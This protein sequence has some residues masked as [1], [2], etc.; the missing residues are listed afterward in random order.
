MN[1]RRKPR[2]DGDDRRGWTQIDETV[3]KKRK[4]A[5]IEQFERCSK[6]GTSYPAGG[7]CPKCR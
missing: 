7:T 1:D 5:V 4:D 6:H 3:E 2:D